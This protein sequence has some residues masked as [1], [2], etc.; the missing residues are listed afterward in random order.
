[1][2]CATCKNIFYSALKYVTPILVEIMREI[3]EMKS[4]M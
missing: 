3:F 2:Y 1:M 4:S